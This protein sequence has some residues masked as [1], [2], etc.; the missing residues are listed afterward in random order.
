MKTE[1][2]E[3]VT[4]NDCLSRVKVSRSALSKWTARGL[5]RSFRDPFTDRRM[6]CIDDVMARVAG[7]MNE[8]ELVEHLAKQLADAAPAL[9]PES[10]EQL[11]SLLGGR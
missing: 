5:V 7:T 10:R 11:A 2:L 6:V 8:A 3:F 9:S 1:K 4:V